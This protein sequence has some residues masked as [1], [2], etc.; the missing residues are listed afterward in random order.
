VQTLV[1]WN[2]PKTWDGLS[3]ATLNAVL[4]EIDAGMEN[5]QRYSSAPRAADRAAWKVVQKH[6]SD[7]TEGQCREIIRTW[8]DNGVLY[9]AAYDD[10]IDRKSR[11]GL[12]L[13]STKR[14]S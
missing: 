5:G 11:Q 6:C 14:P 10:P 4:T 8:V 3:S 2:P 9:E 13:D 1:A 7:R 12:R